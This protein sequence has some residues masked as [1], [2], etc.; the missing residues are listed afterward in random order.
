MLCS[1]Y[2]Y[3]N[4]SLENSSIAVYCKKLQSWVGDTSPGHNHYIYL[5]TF[6]CVCHL[7]VRLGGVFLPWLLLWEYIQFA[8]GAV[9]AFGTAAVPALTHSVPQFNNSKISIA[10]PHISNE[11]D[12]RFRMLVGM[13]FWTLGL[14]LKGFYA[15]VIAV[16]PEVDVGAASVILP[17]RLAHSVILRVCHKGLPILHILCYA[18]HE[19]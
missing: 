3:R 9:Q 18:V 17:A 14:W 5:N 12:L 2:A 10:S 6:A 15:A 4:R 1:G 16:K 11:L 7:L 8:H 19:G 13:V